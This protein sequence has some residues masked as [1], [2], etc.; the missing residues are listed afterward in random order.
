MFC[1]TRQYRLILVVLGMLTTLDVSRVTAEDDVDF[2]RDIRP[3]LADR[4]FHCHGPDEET[5][6]ADLRLDTRDGLL[7]LDDEPGTVHPGDIDESELYRRISSE[8]DHERMP[9]EDSNKQLTDA[10][11]ELFRRWI[12][13]GA[14]WREHW[15]F[16]PPRSVEPPISKFDTEVVHPIDRF[17]HARLFEEGL[18]PASPAARETLIRRLSFDLTG[19][20]PSIAEV[21]RF[22]ADDDPQAYEHAVD[23]LLA[24]PRYGEHQAALWLDLARYA[25]TNGYE[26]DHVREMWPWRDWVIAAFNDDLPFDQFTIEQLAGDLLPNPTEEQLVATGFHRNSPL[27]RENGI[28][29][30][31]YRVEAVADRV[32]TTGTV[33]LGMTI[34]CARCH[35]HKYDPISQVD[36]FRMFAIF[37][38]DANELAPSTGNDTSYR[39]DISPRLR[40]KNVTN[41]DGSPASTLVMRRGKTPRPTYLHQRGNFLSPGEEVAPG[42]PPVLPPLPDNVLADRLG[43]ARWLV[44]G[45]H[46]LTA[47][48]VMNRLW[49][50]YFGQGLVSSL[51]D[52]GLQSAAPTHPA[53]LDW[54][55][56]EFVRR[57]WSMKA[58]HRLIV[59]SNTY[60]QQSAR[61]TEMEEKD[62]LNTLL[63]IFPRRRLSAEQ[64]RD[65]ALAI[66]GLLHEQLGG[67]GVF[68][69][70]PLTNAA[71]NRKRWQSGSAAES[72]RRAIYTFWERTAPYISFQTFDAPTREVCTVQRTVT[73]SPLQALDL[74]N[75]P[76]Y[77][78]AAR[79]LGKAMVSHSEEIDER[80]AFGLRKC[81]ARQPT[82]QELTILRQLFL[83]SLESFR[84]DESAARAW[85]GS[86]A[87]TTSEGPWDL[88]E[89]AAWTLVANSLLNLDET[90][91]R[92]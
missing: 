91:T 40:L 59:T 20:P 49:A 18:A 16:E 89:L 1:W 48:V 80:L 46:P 64:V 71:R 57:G 62:P 63:S 5:R 47:R 3:L 73:S 17:I 22:V 42:T 7:G 56:V 84:Q 68:P 4:C 88:P 34:G 29:I 69:Y 78:E 82:D 75:H 65:N 86:P 90:I 19:L 77:T 31:E 61:T 67:P 2:S 15:A 55:A 35:D 10:E 92:E 28:D 33:W 30:E 52:F 36:Y 76:V 41:P 26:R 6:E 32:N 79:A 81:V 85:S 38:Q 72:H 60:R 45:Q 11:I 8:E 24:S 50:R 51:D 21:E 83:N 70:Q 39:Q 13:A 25:D 87:T 66:S 23:H 53:L 14:P 44:S 9:P 12:S 54:L 27:N 58:M 43:L 37:N 74:L